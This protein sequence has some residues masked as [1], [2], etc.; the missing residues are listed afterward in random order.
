MRRSDVDVDDAFASGW[1]LKMLNQGNLLKFYLL[2]L[3]PTI[4]AM[5]LSSFCT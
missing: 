4:D 3:S 5:K 2:N 1:C